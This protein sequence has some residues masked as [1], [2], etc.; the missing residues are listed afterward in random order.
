MLGRNFTAGGVQAQVLAV[1]VVEAGDGGCEE[2]GRLRRSG[3][4]EPPSVRHSAITTAV[5]EGP[6]PAT[7]RSAR[8]FD[9]SQPSRETEVPGCR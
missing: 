8:L 9:P 1:M 2:A 4:H 5:S 3:R 7:K 6:R